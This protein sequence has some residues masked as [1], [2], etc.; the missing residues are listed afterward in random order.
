MKQFECVRDSRIL[1]ETKAFGVQE[2]T[3]LYSDGSSSKHITALHRGA[4]V[5]VPQREDGTLFLIR[6]YRHSIGRTLLEFPAGSLEPG[7][8]P[9]VAAEREIIEEI[10]HA[11]DEWI[12]LGIQYPTP[13]FCSE[14]QHCY[15]AR[16]LHPAA[17]KPDEDEIIEVVTMS[18][19]EIED[20]IASGEL[21]D[22]KTIAVFKKVK[23]MGLLNG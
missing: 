17:A 6:Q 7:E 23:I 22:A 4:V 15:L 10:Q 19:A 16:R 14:L 5:I 2:E 21:C 9:R 13:G 8:D 11:A 1:L 20:A 3:L 18:A 12:C